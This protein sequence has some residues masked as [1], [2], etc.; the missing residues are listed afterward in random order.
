MAAP[1][2]SPSPPAAASRTPPR[3][4]EVLDKAQGLA[5]QL[6][7]VLG[8]TVRLAVT[9]NR[10]TMVSFRRNPS[11]LQLRLHHMFLDAPP[12]VVEA[13]AD[14]A[15]RG[16]RKAGA[17][18]D[19]YIRERDGHIR[20]VRT[21]D[22]RLQP[23]GRCF[24]LRELYARV[25]AAHFGGAV[26]ASIGWAR[27]PARRRRR[28]IRLGVYEHASREIRI[29]PALD[30]PRVP[31]WFVEFVVFHEMLHQLFPSPAG[32]GRRQHHPRAFRERERTFPL[33]EAAL[34]WEKENLPW[35]LRARLP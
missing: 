10:S 17:V 5:A 35:L 29:H 21:R 19:G 23:L 34:A 3:R 15:G 31:A 7:R 2:S 22:E 11:G 28:T 14:Y 9:D 8:A 24:D 25:N 12:H 27:T 30:D 32:A 4:D 6:S 16:R 18:L 1:A 26:Q 20:R 33:Y 13:L